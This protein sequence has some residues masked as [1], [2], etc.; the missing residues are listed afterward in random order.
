VVAFLLNGDQPATDK[1]AICVQPSA[2]R[3]K[4]A[5]KRSEVLGIDRPRAVKV[6]SCIP[7]FKPQDERAVVVWHV[8]DGAPRPFDRVGCPCPACSEAGHGR[9][10]QEHEAH[11]TFKSRPCRAPQR[12]H[13]IYPG[14]APLGYQKPLL[15]SSGSNIHSMLAFGRIG[16]RSKSR[17]IPR[18]R[19]SCQQLTASR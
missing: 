11:T 10:R 4:R 1:R 8:D 19:T 14:L 6:C 18:H 15:R 9:T 3:L 5:N 13:L 7:C 17:I 12:T 2:P 16:A